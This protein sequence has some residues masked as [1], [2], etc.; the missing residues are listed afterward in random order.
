MT[1]KNKELEELK[2]K[3]AEINEQQV[4]IA[5]QLR[6]IE[7]LNVQMSK[8]DQSSGPQLINL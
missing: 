3:M 1:D 6:K 8:N 2:R 7:E 5:D 4:R